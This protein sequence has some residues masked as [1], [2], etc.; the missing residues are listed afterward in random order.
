MTTKKTI[1]RNPI[2]VKFTFWLLQ[3]I[4]VFF[5]YCL[6]QFIM[7]G[8]SFY[9]LFPTFPN[10]YLFP[11][12][13]AMVFGSLVLLVI[14][15]LFIRQLIFRLE[16]REEGLFYRD[17]SWSKGLIPWTAIKNFS[18]HRSL[19]LK[20][21]F[22]ICWEKEGKPQILSFWAA[23]AWQ[24]PEF[25]QQLSK[26]AGIPLPE[27]WDKFTEK[28]CRRE[29]WGN[30]AVN[31]F[32]L[33]AFLFLLKQ[34]FPV[35]NAIHF[36]SY[37]SNWIKLID[38]ICLLVISW[39][40]LFNHG[41]Q[42]KETHIRYSLLLLFFLLSIP[43]FF[44]INWFANHGYDPEYR[45]SSSELFNN[46]LSALVIALSVGGTF[47][48]GLYAYRHKANSVFRSLLMPACLALVLLFWLLPQFEYPAAKPGQVISL[49]ECEGLN[50]LVTFKDGSV[51]I[52]RNTRDKSG[53]FRYENGKLVKEFDLEDSE[54]SLTSDFLGMTLS[55]DETVLLI[56]THKRDYSERREIRTLFRYDLVSHTLKIIDTHLTEEYFDYF[57]DLY[58]M[59]TW[60]IKSH[61]KTLWA[62]DG[63]KAAFF[64]PV[65][66][67][68]IS[69][70][71][72]PEKRKCDLEEYK[73][74]NIPVLDL[75][76]YDRDKDECHTLS[77]VTGISTN[78]FWLNDGSLGFFKGTG[79]PANW[80]EDIFSFPPR[81]YD[82]QLI[83]IPPSALSAANP[84]KFA[85][86]I[87]WST[88]LSEY[89]VCPDSSWAFEK[90]S[91]YQ[92]IFTELT[93]GQYARVTVNY[94]N[95]TYIYPSPI[96]RPG[97]NEYLANPIDKRTHRE[98]LLLYS[99]DNPAKPKILMENKQ[100]LFYKTWLNE[101]YL[102]CDQIS[103]IY[104]LDMKTM[105]DR[106]IFPLRTFNPFNLK[107]DTNRWTCY[108]NVRNYGLLPFS[109][110]LLGY[111][112]ETKLM[113]VD[114]P[115]DEK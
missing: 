7:G 24:N 111:R 103:G 27:N 5:L 40:I 104:L 64:R 50:G 115:K 42:G 49:G 43:F 110:S 106:C 95:P 92:S 20:R 70:F 53:L 55:P 4:P 102:L 37:P 1:I 44:E 93:S 56:D 41:N 32:F 18:T 89:I 112:S 11:Q 52:I 26:K 25:I 9:N 72:P 3:I 65:S 84:M 51:R 105:K 90:R 97:T 76:I 99:L 47:Y 63:N 16:I 75:I 36:Y 2:S 80:E 71:I 46:S 83:Q 101:R 109:Q 15:L 6:Y 94:K 113:K 114:L 107:T 54:K 74:V 59:A 17:V 29:R 45:Y 58:P 86:T 13:G 68:V 33:I 57:T 91:P 39:Q 82:W 61:G 31:F 10:E 60:N 100:W 62:K 67:S 66:Y 79:D 34:S 87:S 22:D 23:T 77:K 21:K 14:L 96:F 73:K 98:Q 69:T 28:A 8:L 35:L 12:G 19:I 48:T 30:N 81:V 88:G 78:P 108:P 38:F 85:K